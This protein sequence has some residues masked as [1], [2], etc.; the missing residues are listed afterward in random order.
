MSSSYKRKVPADC[1]AC[2]AARPPSYG[3]PD[4]CLGML[5]GVINA[6][7]GHGNR[8]TCYVMFANGPTIR[9]DDARAKQIAMGGNPAEF[10]RDRLPETG[11]EGWKKR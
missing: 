8:R 3:I 6:C 9:Y 1:T 2:G 10:T 7:C 5:P 11:N 4:P